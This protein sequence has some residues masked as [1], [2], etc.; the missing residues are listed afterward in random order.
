MCTD[1]GLIW[2]P[3]CKNVTWDSYTHTYVPTVPHPPS[4]R[5]EPFVCPRPLSP[6]P[7]L[8]SRC[9]CSSWGNKTSSDCSPSQTRPTLRR[10]QTLYPQP[11]ST[12]TQLFLICGSACLKCVFVWMNMHEVA[13]IL[14][15]SIIVV[16]KGFIT[17]YFIMLK[18]S[19][20][21]N[22][23]YEWTETDIF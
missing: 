18:G 4:L 19:K 16:G 11:C 15:K 22:S 13:P 9:R 23:L 2:Q 5:C 6:P 7:L 17:L 3:V 1:R 20:E 21:V 8:L 10:L 12:F 14:H